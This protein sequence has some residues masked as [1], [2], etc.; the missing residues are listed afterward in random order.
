MTASL[1]YVAYYR[2]STAQQG[3]SGLGL[4]AQR[5]AVRLFM[6]GGG[7]AVAE[8]F[9]EVESGKRADRPEL[10]KALVA[11]RLTGAVLVIAKLDRLTR[12][13]AFLSNLMESGVEFVACDNPHATRF[14]IHILA[15]VAE[16]EREMISKRTREALAASKSRREAAGDKPLGGWRGGKKVDPALGRAAIVKAADAFAAGI[17]PTV[18]ALRSGG[19]SLARVA[20]ALKARG[21]KTARGGAWTAAAVRNVLMRPASQVAA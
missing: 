14:T 1:R 9:E 3:R 20:E 19:L 6:T 7:G 10:A 11:C 13:V 17:G 16:H 15:A 12:N 21:F 2:V 5:E 18:T 8:E 4:D